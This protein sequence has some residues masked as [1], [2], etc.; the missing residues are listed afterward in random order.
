MKGVKGKR[1]REKRGRELM[2]ED[3]S[4]AETWLEASD[5]RAKQA[6]GT[7]KQPPSQGGG[8]CD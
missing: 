1:V 2:F 6:R 3:F 8:L 4:L 5:W 7:F